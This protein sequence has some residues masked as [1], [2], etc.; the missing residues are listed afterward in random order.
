MPKQGF[1][2]ISPKEISGE[3]KCA[4][5]KGC[6]TAACSCLKLKFKCSIACKCGEECQNNA[7]DRDKPEDLMESFSSDSESDSE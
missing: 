6:S 5:R 1:E 7:D 2:H 3:L 4:C